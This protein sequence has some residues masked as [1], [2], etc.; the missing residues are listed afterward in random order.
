MF[1][2]KTCLFYS[3]PFFLC[4]YLPHFLT[5]SSIFL[6]DHLH[7]GIPLYPSLNIFHIYNLFLSKKPSFP[8]F[9]SGPVQHFYFFLYSAHFPY[10][11]YGFLFCFIFSVSVVTS[12]CVL[13]LMI[14]RLELPMRCH[15]C[16]LS[17]CIWVHSPHMI[18]PNYIHWHVMFII[19]FFFVTE[20]S[21]V[22]M[23]SIF[24]FQSSVL[25]YLV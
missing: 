13:T 7:P 11:R 18:F 1:L 6:S 4:L 19:S 16:Q 17:F 3:T 9:L 12:C 5:D 14:W 10:P 8:I 2:I 23:S 24:N 25:R 21:I 15:V 20:Y 22:Y